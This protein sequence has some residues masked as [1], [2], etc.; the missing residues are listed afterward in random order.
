MNYRIPDRPN[1][2]NLFL[3]KKVDKI[4]STVYK[5]NNI[6]FQRTQKDLTAMISRQSLQD[7]YYFY[8]WPGTR[9]LMD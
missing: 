9:L 4:R 6:S 8:Y 7:F 2:V 5:K 1:L 3:K